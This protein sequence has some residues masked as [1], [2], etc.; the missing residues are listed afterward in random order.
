MK[1]T[2]KLALKFNMFYEEAW[3]HATKIL[4]ESLFFNP[5]L[6]C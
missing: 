4:T 1:I 3:F 2:K 5:L 6:A